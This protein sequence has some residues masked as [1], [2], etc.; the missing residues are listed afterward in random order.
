MQQLQETEATAAEVKYIL[1]AAEQLLECRL[2]L[3]YSYIVGYY[4][5]DNSPTKSL[6]EFLQENLEKTAEQL[7]EALEIPEDKLKVVNLT[8]LADMRVN[9]FLDAVLDQSGDR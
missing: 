3:K 2:A 7:S 6:F 5:P 1:E 9:N 4:L 8:K